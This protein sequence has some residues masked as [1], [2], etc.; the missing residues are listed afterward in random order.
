MPRGVDQNQ[1]CVMIHEVYVKGLIQSG[2]TNGRHR[3][4]IVGYISTAG[5]KIT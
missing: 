5:I 2:L 1:R 3:A 4:W